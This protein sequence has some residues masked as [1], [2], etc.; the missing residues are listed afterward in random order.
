MYV[1]ATDEKGGDR[2]FF[3]VDRQKTKEFWWS[4]SLKLAMKFYKKSAAE[5]SIKKL[6]YNNPR[7]MT[8]EE[9]KNSLQFADLSEGNGNW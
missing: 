8:V 5:Y 4:P 1:I 7:I 9:A 6:R 3:L 2:T